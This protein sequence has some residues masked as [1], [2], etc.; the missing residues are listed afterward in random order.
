MNSPRAAYLL[1]GCRHSSNSAARHLYFRAYYIAVASQ[2]RKLDPESQS[3]IETY[4]ETQL[5]EVSGPPYRRARTASH[6]SRVHRTASQEHHRSHRVSYH[7][8]TEGTSSSITRTG[9]RMGLESPPYGPPMVF[10]P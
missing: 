5:H 4:E 6:R 1:K 10:Y 2:M 7:T 3:L 9:L 8:I